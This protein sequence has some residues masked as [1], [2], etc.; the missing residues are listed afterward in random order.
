MNDT[1]TQD[2]LSCVHSIYEQKWWLEALAPGAYRCAEVI[3]DNTII[4]RMP[5]IMSKRCG[6]PCVRMPRL[7]KFA[8]PW[9]KPTN[10][11]IANRLGYEKEIINELIDN[12][13]PNCSVDLSLAPEVQYFLPFYW[14]GF[15]VT[16]NITY[17]INDLTDLDKIQANFD[18]SSRSAVRKAEKLL[19]MRDDMPIDVLLE[20]T[21]KTYARQGRKDP[22]PQE[23]VRRL[24]K[25]CRRHNAGKLLCA[26]DQQGKVHSAQYLVYDEKVMFGLLAGSDPELRGSQSN[27]FL[28]WEGI[29][30][31]SKVTKAFDFEGSMIEDLERYLRSFGGSP[32]LYYRVTRFNPALSFFDY[33]RPKIKKM[34][35]YK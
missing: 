6:F 26:V 16:P 1:L 13:P 22:I 9:I 31:A 21:E 19:V 18:H 5:Y 27:S 15:H 35:G 7:T 17:R 24:D 32:T 25:A 2:N 34:I 8:G 30:F 14:R 12:L 23:T 11:K 20:L 29:K 4:G 28:I 3:R 33:I 10:A